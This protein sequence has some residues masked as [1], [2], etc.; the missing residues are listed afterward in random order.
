MPVSG[1]GQLGTG[2]EQTLG[3][4]GDDQVAPVRGLGGD[5]IVHAELADHGQDGFDMAVG[6]R[7]GDP[8][9]VARRD[10]G[11]ALEGALD[12]VDH[13]IG[14]MGQIPQG[15]M[16]DGRSLADG[17]SEQMGD[18]GLTV[19][20]LLCRSHMNGAASCCHTGIFQGLTLAVKGILDVFVATFPSR[21][22][23]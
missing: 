3:D 22:R 11:L 4:H 16:R 13:R 6:E 1:V 9:G 12:E 10:E 7:A 15:L 2:E 21:N 17:P 5:E 14:K 18:V 8:K 23:G 20:D 19:V